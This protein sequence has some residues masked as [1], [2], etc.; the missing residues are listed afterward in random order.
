[1]PREEKNRV[2]KW[3]GRVEGVTGRG[4]RKKS[5][6]DVDSISLRMHLKKTGF[7][8]LYGIPERFY[9]W[10]ATHHETHVHICIYNRQDV[11][12]YCWIKNCIVVHPRTRRGGERGWKYNFKRVD[13]ENC[14][15][16]FRF[17]LFLGE[18]MIGGWVYGSVL[19][20]LWFSIELNLTTIHTIIV[21]F[22]FF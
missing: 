22:F 3:G 17:D 18:G 1:M 15:T 14:L 20:G 11:G 7:R 5:S 6:S 10:I 21:P 8:S 9:I 16:V 2:G 4:G 12:K 19:P 13:F